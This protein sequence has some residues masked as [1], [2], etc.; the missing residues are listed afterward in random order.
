MSLLTAGALFLFAQPESIL[1]QEIRN[2]ITS[3][4]FQAV[5]EGITKWATAIAV[6]LSTLMVLISAYLYMFSAGD[7]KK[8]DTAR[9]ALTW[10]LVGFAIVLIAQS[11]A[12]LIKNILGVTDP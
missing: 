11:A 6:P 8:L 10:A 3:Q 9:K 7:P 4:T 1:A 12:A 2:P 5:V